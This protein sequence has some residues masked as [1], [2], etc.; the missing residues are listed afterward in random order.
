M[1]DWKA[2]KI[3]YLSG[4]SVKTVT[5]S[6]LNPQ[7]AI[8]AKCLDCS[9]G[10]V[11]VVSDCS[12]PDCPLYPFR[13]GKNPMREKRVMSDEQRQK[14]TELLAKARKPKP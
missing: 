2:H 6:T 13:L 14:A 4:D 1:T 5:A 7:R 8:R 10:S 9:G 3:T 12:C 11:Q